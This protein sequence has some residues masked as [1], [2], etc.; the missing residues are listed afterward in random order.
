M[1]QMQLHAQVQGHSLG[2]PSCLSCSGPGRGR[3]LLSPS[4]Q[5]LKVRAGA[6]GA[7]QPIREEKFERK[8][9]F[10]YMYGAAGLS[11]QNPIRPLE[12]QTM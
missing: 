8:F 6:R 1:L 9:S 12:I 4:C 2:S 7:F 3:F 11:W 5:N 10:G